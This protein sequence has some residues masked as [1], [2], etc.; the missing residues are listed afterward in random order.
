MKVKDLKHFLAALPADADE[1]DVL[2]GAEEID[3][4]Y[5]ITG[6]SESYFAHDDVPEGVT[7]NFILLYNGKL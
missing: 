6:A 7:E 3:G 1:Q 4:I 2:F 5:V